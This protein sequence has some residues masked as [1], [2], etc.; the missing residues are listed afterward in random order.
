MDREG[1]KESGST[2]VSV[3]IHGIRGADGDI[4]EDAEAVASF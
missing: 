4:I 1:S 3:D 2:S